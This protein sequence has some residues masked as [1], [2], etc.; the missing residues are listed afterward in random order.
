[1][2]CR[3]TT[4]F[5][6]WIRAFLSMQHKKDSSWK[7][8]INDGKWI[9]YDNPKRRI[10]RLW[11]VFYISSRTICSQKKGLLCICISWDTKSIINYVIY[12]KLLQ[13]TETVKWTRCQLNDL[14]DE[15][16]EKRLFSRQKNRKFNLLHDNAKPHVTKTT[17]Q[18]NINLIRFSM[19]SVL[20]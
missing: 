2:N 13:S 1:M 7:V 6:D 14:A 9:M 20:F 5:T 17:Q 10:P 11:T 19:C 4:S 15:I 3:K 16:E 8:I 18:T 12:Y